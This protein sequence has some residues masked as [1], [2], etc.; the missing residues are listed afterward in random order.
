[1]LITTITL[2]NR[3]H[4]GWIA[5]LDDGGEECFVPQAQIDR[6]PVDTEFTAVLIENKR[7]WPKWFCNRIR[8]ASDVLPGDVHQ[9]MRGLPIDGYSHAAELGF[10]AGLCD[11]IVFIRGK[12]D[13]DAT[14][15]VMYVKNVD[16]YTIEEGEGQ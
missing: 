9:S 16:G 3:T 14:P 15:R 11:K 13:V 7:Q 12:K 10:G 1:M 2:V 5:R 8:P 6:H 4:G